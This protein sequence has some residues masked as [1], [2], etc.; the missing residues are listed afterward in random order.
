MPRSCGLMVRLEE[1]DAAVEHIMHRYFATPRMDY[2]VIPG[3]DHAAEL[4]SL[5]FELQQLGSRDLPWEEEDAERTR[6]RAEY[7][8]VSELPVVPDQVVEVD[9]GETYAG[10]FE[11]LRPADR[12]PWLRAEGFVIRATKTL[13]RVTQGD[14]EAEV[15]LPL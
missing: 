12:G 13:V 10:L 5:K 4:A 7:N 2:Q 9:T 1:V 15:E 6:L 14:K 8:R 11:A 3:T